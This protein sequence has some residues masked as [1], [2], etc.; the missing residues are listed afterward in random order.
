MQALQTKLF[1][2]SV[3]IVDCV[4]QAFSCPTW[5]RKYITDTD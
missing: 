5:G 1:F 3:K 4:S 2:T